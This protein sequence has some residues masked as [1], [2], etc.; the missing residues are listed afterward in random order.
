[1]ALGIQNINT[2]VDM[3]HHDSA[4]LTQAKSHHEL[5]VLVPYEN[6]QRRFAPTEC[7]LHLNL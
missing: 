3:R 5:L 4:Q 2:V 6:Q 7:S 1:M